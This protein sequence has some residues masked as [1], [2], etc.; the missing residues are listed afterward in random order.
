MC[1]ALSPARSHPWVFLLLLLLQ[2]AFTTH[3]LQ[4]LGSHG[5]RPSGQ[6]FPGRGHQTAPHYL[7]LPHST[8]SWQRLC[9]SPSTLFLFHPKLDD[10]EEGQWSPR[11][12]SSP[13]LGDPPC[14]Y[15]L[16]LSCPL[17]PYPSSPISQAPSLLTGS[18]CPSL[19]LASIP[20]TSA[21]LCLPSSPPL[22]PQTPLKHFQIVS[23]ELPAP[24]PPRWALLVPA[25]G[26]RPLSECPRA[27]NIPTARQP[28]PPRSR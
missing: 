21:H 25:A 24:S 3:S 7:R 2:S 18:R 11:L 5:T 23:A 17:T 16:A 15:K 20:F 14:S 26:P 13:K 19:V 28:S 12:G 6:P 22:C 27:P 8:C 9:P 10:E 4:P 1:I